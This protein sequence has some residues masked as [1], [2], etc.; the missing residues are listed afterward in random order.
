M[1]ENDK[2]PECPGCKHT[3]DPANE[4]DYYL[5]ELREIECEK[6]GIMFYCE[7]ESSVKTR[8]YEHDYMWYSFID[9]E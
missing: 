4:P 2:G 3:H 8:G 9:E 1:I 7:T 5:E 6:C